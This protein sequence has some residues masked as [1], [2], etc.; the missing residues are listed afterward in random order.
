MMTPSD[1]ATKCTYFD[2]N[3]E[4]TAVE[5][6]NRLVGKTVID[7]LNRTIIIDH[8]HTEGKNGRP[9]FGGKCIAESPVSL[10]Y[11]GAVGY[12]VWNYISDIR[13]VKRSDKHDRR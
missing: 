11:A 2:E 5:D 10:G 3:Y 6:P 9:T 4:I 13:E 8:I 12:D 7:N 1:D